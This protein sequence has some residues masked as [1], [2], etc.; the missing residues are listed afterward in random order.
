MRGHRSRRFIQNQADADHGR[1][2]EHFVRLLNQLG[3][4]ALVVDVV[5][6]EL[7]MRVIANPLQVGQGT[8]G[9]IVQDQH[10]PSSSE[11]GLHEVAAYKTRAAGDQTCLHA[12]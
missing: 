12:W 9:Q 5:D 6:K 1:Q 7:Q 4:T 3:H 11:Q 10:A 8:S 2:V